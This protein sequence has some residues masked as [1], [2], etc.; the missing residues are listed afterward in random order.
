MRPTTLSLLIFLL[1]LFQLSSASADNYSL[2]D[3]IG[4]GPFYYCSHDVDDE[5]I[6]SGKV[7]IGKDNNL[8]ITD[9]ITLNITG[10]FKVGD[11]SSVTI[12]DEYFFNVSAANLHIDGAA[13]IVIDELEASGNVKIHKQANLTANVT[14]TNGYIEIDEGNNT[15]IGNIAAN[16]GHVYISGGNNTITGN[17]TADDLT[18]AQSST[19]VNGTCVPSRSQ[20]SPPMV[21][22]TVDSQTTFNTTPIITGTFSSSVTTSFTVTVNSVIYTLSSS[23]ELSNASDNWT[24][25]L[26][27][28]TPLSIGT[29]N[30]LATSTDGNGSLSDTTTNEL[31]IKAIA[32]GWW[33]TNWTKCRNIT[34]DNTGSSTLS[35]FPAYIDLDYDDDMQSDYSDI[36]FINTSCLN[37]GLELDF[38]IE[39]DTGESADVWVE[40]DSLPAAGTTIAVYYGNSSATSGQDA[41]GTWDS[42]HQGVWHLSDSTDADN[43]DST[44]NSNNGSPLQSPSS[45]GGKIGNSLNFDNNN[46]K[47]VAL[48]TTS[49]LNLSSYDD[50]TISVWVKPFTDFADNAYPVIYTYGSYGASVGLSES[51][52]RIENWRNDSSVLYNSTN[53]STNDW[54]HVVV[55]RTSSTTRFYLNGVANGTGSS[56]NINNDS[57]GSYIGGWSTYDGSSLKGKIDEVRVSNMRRSADWIKQS[58]QLVENQSTHVTISD[59]I[60]PRPE[61]DQCSAIFPDG[62]STHS[63]GGEIVF[64]YNT[65]LIDSYYNQLATTDISKNNGSNISTCSSADCIASGTASEAILSTYFKGTNSPTDVTVSNNGSVV[66]GSGSFS[67][68]E[69]DEINP[70][71]SNASITFSNSH[72]EYFVDSLILGNESTLYL[73]AGTTYWINELTLSTQSEI[74]VQGTGTALVYA[75]QDLT[76]PFNGLINSSSSNNS[77]DASKLAMFVFGDVTLSSGSTYTGSLYAQG[78]LSLISSSYV[79]G[80]VNAANISLGSGSTIT[81]QSA[82]VAD[83]DFRSMCEATLPPT[84]ILNYRFDALS[85]IGAANL[86]TDSSGNSNDGTAVGGIT[87]TNG[88]ICNA[89][90]IP[91]NTSASIYEA[92]D[93]GVDLD[94][95]IGSSGTISLWYRGNTA[96]NSGTAKRLFDASDGSKYFFAEIMANG[97]VIFGFEDGSD[98]D[99]FKSTD[100]PLAVD[101]GVWKHLIFVW[102][103]TTS[104]AQIFVDGVEQ[105]LS[106][107]NGGTAAFI[108]LDTLY[109]GDNR[110]ATYN[111]GESSADGRIDEVL[112]FNSVLTATQVQTIFSNQDA[113]NNYDGSPRTCPIAPAAVCGDNPGGLTAVGININSNNGASDSQINSTTEALAI[114]AAWL[115][116]GSPSS[117]LIDSTPYNVEA[118]GA[119][120][121]DRIDF[122]GHEANFSSTLSYPGSNDTW[123]DEFLVHISGTISLPAGDYTILVRSD[124]GFSFIMDTLSGDTVSFNRFGNSNNNGGNELRFENGTGNSNTGGSFTL[125]QD[126]VFDIAAIFYEHGGGDYLEIA[127]A[128]GTTNSENIGDYEILRDGALTDNKVKLGQCPVPTPVADYHFDE[129]SW[130]G[131]AGEL[132]DSGVNS[133]H[134]QSDGEPISQDAKICKGATFDGV[135]DH[136]VLPPISTDFSDGFSAMAWVDFGSADSWERVI[137]FA[138]GTNNNNILLGRNTTTNNLTFEIYNGSNSCSQITAVSGIQSGRHHYAV[139]VDPDRTVVLYRDGVLIHSGTSSCLPANVT[140]NL[141][142]VGRSNWSGNAYFNNTID[143]LKVFDSELSASNIA[144]IYNNE[145]AGNNFDGTARTCPAPLVHHYEIIH[146]G[147]GLTCE[148][149]D[150]TVNACIDDSC[151][152]LSA[153]AVTLDFLSDGALI[154]T[155]TFIGSTVINVNNVDVETVTFALANA[156]I[157]AAN[158]TVCSNGS[159]T[160]CDMAFTNAGFRFLYGAGASTTVANQIAG[161]VFADTL[162]LQ[163]VKDVNGV[164][165]ELFNSNKTVELSQENVDPGGTS[166]LSFTTAGNAIA[167]H[168][169]VT[170]TTLSF[171]ANSTATIPSPLYFDAGQIRLH[172]N[173]ADVNGINVSGNS[174]PFW[175]SPAQLVVTAQL[176]GVDLNGATATAAITHPAGEDFDISISAFNAASPPA[177]TQNYST[178]QIQFALMRTGPTLTGSID[179][180]LRYAASGSLA[181][182]TSPA[183]QNVTLTS[184][185]AGVSTY[186]AA[187]YSEVGLLNLDVQDS[188]Y[189]NASIVIPATAINIGRFIPAHFT[190]TVAQAG[191]FHATC[192]ASTAFTAFSG[193]MDEASSSIGAISYLLNPVLAITAYNKQGNITQNYY[194]DSQGSANDFMKLSAA[195]V[196]INLPT[197]D[198]VATGVNTSLLPLSANMNT[199]TLSQND[200]IA[201]PSV[202]LPKGVLHY[203]LADNDHFFYNRSANAKVSPFTSDIAFTVASITDA[204]DVDVTSTATA[205]PDGITIRFGRL[206][207]ENSFGPETTNLAQVM[208]LEHFDGSEFTTSTDNNC[209]GYDPSNITLSNISVDPARTDVLGNIGRF[210]SGISQGIEFEAPGAGTQGQLGVTYETYYWLQYDWDNNGAYDNDPTAIATFGLYRGDDRL[211]HWREVF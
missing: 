19:V 31:E 139:T 16:N 10:E 66:V 149:E 204:D 69:F 134:G 102:D 98:G 161:T 124:D 12:N 158:A 147:Q 187:Q 192:D 58:Y 189:G 163:A 193:Q 53:L 126:S 29:Y 186:N 81:Y 150:I 72:V 144:D 11:D 183:F 210:Q 129:L 4:S 148:A 131:T 68:N 44:A 109:F 36:R 46:D 91:S 209:V 136:F 23:S 178:G 155:P 165:T 177:I 171:G 108:N 200:L 8:L 50:W 33:D 181:S 70:G 62:A 54:H 117:G 88:K 38:E 45:G 73:Q 1:L 101:A 145:N 93:T 197:T 84:P 35:N 26:S 121:V 169:S 208:T 170:N 153:E 77:G 52:G 76:F 5:Y 188:N 87:T 15:I 89:A 20:C 176:A 9:N 162:K 156:S 199:G 104:T 135:N 55:T 195:D 80:A 28:I 122:G 51:N 143:E 100:S 191:E 65:Q 63:S 168:P 201:M 25:N 194:Q 112:V 48:G 125:S 107:S 127:I 206:W 146:D 18:I 67:G 119:S 61:P 39:K 71:S 6:C 196:N 27:N 86:V 114:H 203:Q 133:L 24:L 182:S 90:D 59:E 97:K 92:V 99:Y 42:N 115:D 32:T 113:D 116:A 75:N 138:N 47:R 175:V 123:V 14:S 137:D 82:E 22:P 41:N 30:V 179:G 198:Q 132:I 7:D 174:N 106:G 34:I 207:L 96:W 157:V 64:G 21:N 130:D 85:W 105:S 94:A 17:I 140:R 118:S 103:V 184:F 160:S 167:K 74:I 3:D 78:D 202:A 152:I 60:E 180:G 173:Y 110:D 142:Y 83:T 43:Q 2:P 205:S 56:V 166:G 120:I 185:S 151:S 154:S 190:Q 57:T 172:A 128:D 164:C 211:F 159:G 49:S 37:G 111:A 141:N 79:F 13:S 40:I 95:D